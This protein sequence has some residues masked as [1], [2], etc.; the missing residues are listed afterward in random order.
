MKKFLTVVLTICTLFANT[1]IYAN[2]DPTSSITK[3]EYDDSAKTITV[4]CV[5]TYMSNVTMFIFNGW[6]CAINCGDVKEVTNH[7]FTFPTT[8]AIGDSK[9]IFTLTI[10]ANGYDNYECDVNIGNVKPLKN[11]PND[12]SIEVNNDGDLI[13]Y[14]Q[15]EDF[16]NELVSNYEEEEPELLEGIVYSQTKDGFY[17]YYFG[18]HNDFDREDR[19][20]FEPLKYYKDDNIVVFSVEDQQN[21][22]MAQVYRGQLLN[23]VGY[24]VFLS[25]RGYKTYK[26]ANT[27]YFPKS[28]TRIPTN[29]VGIYIADGYL[30]VKALDSTKQIALDFINNIYYAGIAQFDDDDCVV[31][32]TLIG[33]SDEVTSS[34][35]DTINPNSDRVYKLYAD[36]PNVITGYQGI[37]NSAGYGQ[38]CWDGRPFGGEVYIKAEKFNVSLKGNGSRDVNCQ[39]IGEFEL[40]AIDPI[41]GKE[42]VGWK[43][44]EKGEEVNRCIGEVVFITSDTEIYAI[45]KDSPQPVKVDIQSIVN[46]ANKAS[47]IEVDGNE[48]EASLG[49]T[50]FVDENDVENGVSV[51]LE[52]SGGTQEDLKQLQWAVNKAYDDENEVLDVFDANVFKKV[53]TSQTE[54]LAETEKDVEIVFD[55]TGA[56]ANVLD[57]AKRGELGVISIHNGELQEAIGGTFDVVTNLFTVKVKKFSTYGLLKADG[58]VINTGNGNRTFSIPKTGIR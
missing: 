41:N 57:L 20:D 29:D 26:V 48:Y 37:V 31:D 3:V 53:G 55:L 23:D 12:L 28:N 35:F 49:N 54:K 27:L 30:I 21:I 25:V 44:S 4:E 19:D 32:G 24:H 2:T 8:N 10:I 7:S 1:T 6:D 18:V 46:V 38:Y 39:A 15:D 40:P 52:V 50:S 11:Y 34:V 58:R 56:N 13:I 33:S 16:M 17:D 5:E 45:Y 47:I 36:A 42:I 51:W 43:V 9:G 22:N 14:S